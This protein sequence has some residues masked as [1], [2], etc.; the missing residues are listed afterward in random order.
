MEKEMKGFFRPG[1]EGPHLDQVVFSQNRLTQSQHSKSRIVFFPTP[2]TTE[3]FEIIAFPKEY[4]LIMGLR[5]AERHTPL[6]LMQ[7]SISWL[8][9]K[10]SAKKC[11]NFP[12]S[13]RISRGSKCSTTL[14]V[15]GI[16]EATVFPKS[17]S[18]QPTWYSD[19]VAKSERKLSQ[20]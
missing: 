17:T 6:C 16:L 20:S 10:S 7:C 19:S 1:A 5:D 15:Q 2:I 9:Q 8:F 18:V 14:Q 11:R 3:M 4:H 13:F 12:N